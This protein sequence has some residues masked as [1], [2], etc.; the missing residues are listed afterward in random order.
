[1]KKFSLTL[2]AFAMTAALALMPARVT[3][4]QPGQAP[5]AKPH[6]VALIDLAHIFQNYEKFKDQTQGLQTA[7]QNAQA[8]AVQMGEDLKAKQTALQSLTPGSPDYSALESQLFEAQGKLQ[9]FQQVEQREIVRKQAELYKQIYMDVQKAT[10][11]YA[12]YYNYTLVLRFNRADATEST[13]PQQILQGLN[14]QVVFYQTND[15]ITDQ[16]LDYLNDTYRK[17]ASAAP[18][19]P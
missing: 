16:I 13:N 7:A 1:M 10:S 4:Q 15:D 18:A 6:Q 11:E 12:R 5:A 9:A 14:R 17:T 8:K 2:M 19:R 3:A